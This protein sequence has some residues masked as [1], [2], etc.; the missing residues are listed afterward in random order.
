MADINLL[1]NQLKSDAGLK[2]RRY[3]SWTETGIFIILAVFVIAGVGFFVW[4]NVARR[5]EANAAKK[6]EEQ[7]IK[8]ASAVSDKRTE[9]I[10]TQGQILNLGSLLGTHTYWS[11]LFALINQASVSGMQ[12]THLAAAAEGNLLITGLAPDF[13]SI[14]TFNKRL[15]TLP[16][17]KEVVLNSSSLTSTAERTYYNFTVSVKFSPDLL[18]FSEK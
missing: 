7:K 13:T 16:H 12:I 3:F 2:F 6:I 11:N 17:I 4:N 18:L 1:Q 8:L 5:S 9:V 10:K 15:S 14:A